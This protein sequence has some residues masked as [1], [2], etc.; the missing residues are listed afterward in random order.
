MASLP[1]ELVYTILSHSLSQILFDHLFIA[2]LHPTDASHTSEDSVRWNPTRTNANALLWNGHPSPPSA[3]GRP[4]TAVALS[5][6]NDLSMGGGAIATATANPMKK[7]R[8]A[9]VNGGPLDEIS[10]LASVC[11]GWRII[12]LRILRAVLLLNDNNNHNLTH[13]EGRDQLIDG[14]DLGTSGLR[15]RQLIRG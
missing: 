2:P 7:N 12:V 11:V 10:S 13:D 3:G 9:N 15:D 1:P 8:N 5:R 6:V 14:T 4:I